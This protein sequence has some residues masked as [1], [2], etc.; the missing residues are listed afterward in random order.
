MST[1][2]IV[3]RE[4]ADAQREEHGPGQ[5]NNNT[6][7]DKPSGA[8]V[9]IASS[10]KKKTLHPSTRISRMN[11]T[12]RRPGRR[13]EMQ[14]RLG[15][16]PAATIR[17]TREQVTYERILSAT[18]R[19][20][21][22]HAD[23][24]WTPPTEFDG[25]P[26]SELFFVSVMTAAGL[27]S[28]GQPESAR[29]LLDRTLPL[30]K[31]MLLSHHPQTFYMLVEMSM[32]TSSSVIGNL[33]ASI[34]NHLAGITSSYLGK[35]HPMAILLNTPL[36][37]DQ[38]TRLRVDAQKMAHEEQVKT[39]GPLAYQTL[40]HVWYWARSL[41]G[42]GYLEEA[43]VMLERLSHSWDELYGPNSALAI[44]GL[45]EQARV[46]LASGSASVKVE[47]LISD[48]LRRNKVL[49]MAH[50]DQTQSLDVAEARQRESSLLFSR[51][52]A[53]RLLGRVHTMRWNFGAALHS[54]EQAMAIAEVGL[55][56]DSSVLQ[57]CR[58]D[59]DAARSMGLESAMGV[60][61]VGDPTSRLS[62]I[63][64]V[65]PLMP[66]EAGQRHRSGG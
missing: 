30:A 9:T 66:V 26:E 25:R 46:V 59:L 32:D 51:L 53:L 58:A 20:Y 45:V 52:A 42:A 10:K 5:I 23:S 40:S 60:L 56:P 7:T 48:A 49:S 16:A 2:A 50:S 54:F 6:E 65:I 22:G 24:T 18:S 33:R 61:T 34:K 43:A 12:A 44:I 19:Y 62:T 8:K 39:F 3:E 14:W 15:Q 1:S 55:E 21:Q 36:T 47:C 64:S 28:A 41:A 38:R 35:H 57:L 27:I 31:D 17:D 11:K 4:S 29:S 63:N 13:F 37:M